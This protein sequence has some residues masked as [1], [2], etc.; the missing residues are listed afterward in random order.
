MEFNFCPNCGDP[1]KSQGLTCGKCGL[2]LPSYSNIRRTEFEAKY[3]RGSFQNFFENFLESNAD[4]LKDLAAKVEKGKG[5]EKGMFFAVEMK[6]DKPVIRS[7]DIKEFESFFKESQF[8]AH[9]N[10]MFTEKDKSIEFKEAK[11]VV[12]TGSAGKKVTVEIPGVKNLADVWMNRCEDGLEVIGRVQND[13]Y[14]CKIHIKESFTVKSTRLE[15]SVLH[16]D[17]K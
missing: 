9:L 5:F 1:F 15:D 7:G 14:F 6:G 8:P 13:I 17:F 12:N 11:V 16:I 3:I 2:K 10:Q 4:L